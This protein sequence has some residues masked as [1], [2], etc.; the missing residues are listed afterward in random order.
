MAD[1]DSSQERTEEATP[2]RLQQAREKGQVARSKEL[3]TFAVLVASAIGFMTIGPMLGDSLATIMTQLFSPS[4][5][6]I[7]DEY[8]ML[9]VWGPIGQEL[10]WPLLGFISLLVFLALWAM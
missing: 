1:N 4:R 9:R 2:K 5:A 3:G 6:N 7:F 10:G 8:S